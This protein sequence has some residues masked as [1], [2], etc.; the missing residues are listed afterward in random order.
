MKH[1]GELN[2]RSA[3]KIAEAPTYQRVA[4]MRDSRDKFRNEFAQRVGIAPVLL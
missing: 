4:C 1:D 3:G 2:R